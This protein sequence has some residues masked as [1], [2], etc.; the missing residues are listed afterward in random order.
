[1]EQLSRIAPDGDLARTA[2]EYSVDGLMVIDGEGVVQFAN[3]A[4]ILLFA[5]RTKE[6]LGF[7]IGI[8]AIREP[9][10]IM[11]P[12]PNYPCYVEMRCTEIVWA[13][14]AASLACLRDITERKQAEDA[15]R[16]QADE[17]RERNY[18]LVRFTR[19]AVGRELRMIELKKEVNE[20][21]LLV[22]GALRHRIPTAEA[23]PMTGVVEGRLDG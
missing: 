10:E 22:G 18:E 9:M 21:C 20:L 17:L 1:M 4:A 8:P 14:Q 16:K 19:A 12:G 13:G 6:L 7:H 5:N 2:I 23:V 3:P 11:L 15:V